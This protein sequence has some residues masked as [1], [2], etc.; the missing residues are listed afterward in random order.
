MNE[1]SK[2]RSIVSRI[3]LVV[4]ILFS[5]TLFIGSGVLWY[6]SFN[7]R[8]ELG[9]YTEDKNIGFCSEHGSLQPFV[10][11]HAGTGSSPTWW[12]YV[13]D[14]QSSTATSLYDGWFSWRRWGFGFGWNHN[15]KNYYVVEIPYWLIM[16]I[17]ILPA[18]VWLRRLR[19]PAT[20]HCAKCGYDLRGS[21]QSD[22]CPECGTSIT[23]RESIPTATSS[24]EDSADGFPTAAPPR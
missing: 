14:P 15:S 21:E 7:F 6:M 13:H 18:I 3:L 24:A 17:T 1:Y 4:V 2:Q 23:D 10:T 20:G 12:W 9:I 22:T 5:M 19:K 11:T 8:Q 16:V